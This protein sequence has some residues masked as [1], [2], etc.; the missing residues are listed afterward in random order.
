MTTKAEIIVIAPELSS[1][2]DDQFT[3]TISL[4]ESIATEFKFGTRV[5]FAQ[6]YL[7][8]HYL[9]LIRDISGDAGSS[10]GS[11]GTVGSLEE[12][13]T[14]KLRKK[15]RSVLQDLKDA[16]RFDLTSY[17][18]T[19]NSIPALTGGGMYVGGTDL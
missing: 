15:W 12:E 9:T 5:N 4:A 3:A 11:A 6:T 2:S 8:A 1:M 10:A 14:E 19:Y 16:N 18:R 13:Q 7:A 17:G